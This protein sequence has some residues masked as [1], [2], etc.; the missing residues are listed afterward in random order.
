MVFRRRCLRTFPP[1]GRSLAYRFGAFQLL[2]QAALQGW[3]P[4][5]AAPNQIM[6][7]LTAVIH[8][9]IEAPGTFVQ[10]GW[11]RVG[12]CGDQADIGEGYISTGSLY[13]CATVFLP[14]GLNPAHSSWQGQAD[15]TSKKAW[16]GAPFPI[17][18]ALYDNR[19]AG[20]GSVLLSVQLAESIFMLHTVLVVLPAENGT[21]MRILL[22]GGGRIRQ[23][24]QHAVRGPVAGFFFAQ[25]KFVEGDI[26]KISTLR[27][28]L[29]PIIIER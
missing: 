26:V 5:E 14:L 8:R 15:W 16:A 13:L 7:A 9:M 4:E 23:S 27:N 6:C 19:R 1:L 25:R 10:D 12:F 17:D 24:P 11:L 2:S 18:K 21:R 29:K 20:A 28:P 22:E 3:L